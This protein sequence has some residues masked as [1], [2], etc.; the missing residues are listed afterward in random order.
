VDVFV[1]NAVGIQLR[2]SYQNI[3]LMMVVSKSKLAVVDIAVVLGEIP[4][5]WL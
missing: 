4:T 5:F 3:P 1:V 2:N